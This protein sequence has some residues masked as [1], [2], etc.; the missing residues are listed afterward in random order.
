MSLSVPSRMPNGMSHSRRGLV[1]SIVAVFLI[2]DIVAAIPFPGVLIEREEDLKSSYDYVVVGGGTAGLTV[3]NRLSEDKH[4]SVL[5][6]EAGSLLPENQDDIAIPGFSAALGFKYQWGLET[7]P[8]TTVKDNGTFIAPSPKLVGGDSAINSMSYHRGSREDYDSWERLGN[9]GWGWEG[10]LPYFKK[11]ETFHPPNKA[12]VREFGITYDPA[13]HGTDGPVQ[14]KFASFIYP[15]YRTIV[16]A[17]KRLGVPVPFDASNG[18]AIGSLWIA[19]PIDPKDET[20]SYAR[21]AYHDVAARRSNYHLVTDKQVTKILFD[22]KKRATGVLYAKSASDTPKKVSAKTEVILSGGAFHN[23][24]LL[25]LSGI[26]PKALLKAH[27]IP[28]LV[29]LPGVGSNLQDHALIR[30]LNFTSTPTPD[31]PYIDPTPALTNATYQAEQLAQY[32]KDRTG[33][34]TRPLAGSTVAYLPLPILAPDS[35]KKIVQAS[36]DRDA[37]AYL[38]NPSPA[39]LAGYK[40]QKSMILDGIEAKKLAVAEL[41][42]R[43]GIAPGPALIVQKPLSRGY[44]EISSADAFKD[45]LIYYRTFSDPTDIATHIANIRYARKFFASKGMASF[46]TV[47]T[48]PGKD[49]VSDEE[50]A[51]VARG[52]VVNPSV[53]H[54]SCTCPMMDRKLGGVVDDKL[55]VYGVT[56][57]RIVDISIMPIIPS[58]HMVATRFAI[59]EKA[60]DIIKGKK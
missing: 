10:I 1:A 56:G 35:Y 34:Y 32:R 14:I 6:I 48:Y 20:R 25:Q 36:R 54:A 29:D 46:K 17:L 53:G 8:I 11:A 59:A 40:K 55:R 52:R 37:S 23:P 50:L 7:Q 24:K 51:K 12:Q 42:M 44:V 47:E 41:S 19:N 33:Y 15:Q 22:E 28:V 26:G 9:K 3:A 49:V 57:L 31:T 18:N 58:T 43:P 4:K 30:P 39:V 21:T 16:D 38:H 13:A 60:A 5:V 2:L 27:K 45:P